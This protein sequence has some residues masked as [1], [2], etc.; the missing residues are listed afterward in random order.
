MILGVIAM[1]LISA[2]PVQA[3][4]DDF[5]G[6]YIGVSASAVGVE[7]DG[8]HN[9]N[10]G[11][12]TVGSVG[13]F[14]TIAGV[15]LGYAIP[16]GSIFLI[17]I[18]GS[19][20]PGKAQFKTD[21]D[22]ASRSNS[23]AVTFEV[24]DLITGYI[25]PTISLGETSSVYLKLGTVD[26]GLKIAGNVTKLS[27]MDGTS[28]AIGSRTMMPGGLYIKTEAGVV[29]YD[30]LSVSGLTANTETPGSNQSGISTKTTV[31]ADPTVAYGKVSIGYKF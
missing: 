3:G 18:G 1:A 16:V 11:N 8:N 4:S 20:V 25:A 23:D 24:K 2:T 29:D 7:L 31:T 17:D 12:V 6:A 10:E 27:G 28:L 15:E 14:A 19:W 26:A 21:T 13:K 9:D 5:A 30:S 22:L